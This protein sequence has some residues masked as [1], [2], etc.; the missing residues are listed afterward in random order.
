VGPQ[1]AGALLFIA[2][3]ST[4]YGSL[5][6]RLPGVDVSS[7]R[8]R[9]Q[10]TPLNAPDPD[11]PAEV[12]NAADD[13][14]TEAFHTAMLAAALMCAAGA[15]VNAVGIKDRP[16]DVGEEHGDVVAPSAQSP[17]VEVPTSHA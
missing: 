8:L 11:V 2:I 6:D 5:S 7:Q 3:T 12:E 9:E 10:V 16:R 17:C 1:L 13:A 4:F 15:A 14:S